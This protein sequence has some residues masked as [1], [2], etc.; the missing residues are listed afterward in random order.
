MPELFGAMN[1]ML[2]INYVLNHWSPSSSTH[3]AHV[4]NLLA[5]LSNQGCRVNLFIEK[6]PDGVPSIPGVRVSR[7]MIR[8]PIFRHMELM[9]RLSLEIARGYRATFIRISA[10][11]AIAASLC[12]SVLGGR[13]FLWQSGATH[14]YDWSR[15]LGLA[16]IKWIL[17]SAIP[18]FVA[19]A[20]CQRFVT[21]PEAMVAYYQEVVGIAPK[22]IR[23]LYNDINLEA[24]GAAPGGSAPDYFQRRG[25]VRPRMVLVLVHRLS[26]VRK[27][28]MY[29][30]P[31]LQALQD[32]FAKDWALLVAG[33]GSELSESI[34]IA[35]SVG[36]RECCYFLGPVPNKELAEIYASA[37]VFINPSNAEGFPRVILEAMAFNLPIVTTDAGGTADLLGPS[38]TEWV[39][40]RNDPERFAERVID[41]LSDSDAQ[42]ALGL[43]NAQIVQ[44]FSTSSVAKMY[45]NVLGGE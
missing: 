29:L 14:E 8:L 25:A 21:G 38:Q 5:V 45:A 44:R 18:N 3:F 35:E 4:E 42:Q 22:K 39:V 1:K 17:G 11:A 20:V 30:R 40:D 2:K 13:A 32:K 7:L 10:P 16:K 36:V 15:P 24:W 28:T 43:E 12:H 33:D 37:D 26:P 19:R 9:L 31:L 41:L 6:A 23:L 34:E 27:T